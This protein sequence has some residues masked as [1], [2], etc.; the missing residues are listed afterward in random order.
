MMSPSWIV[1]E[2]AMAPRPQVL[3]STERLR[4]L[5]R[6][7]RTARLNDLYYGRQLTIWSRMIGTHDVL[8]AL[9]T[10]ASPIAFWKS[11]SDPRLHGAWVT[12]SVFT[13]ILGALKPMLSM[14]DRLKVLSEL[15]T[16]YCELFFN[17]RDLSNEAA[18]RQ[19]YTDDLDKQ[20]ALLR[21]SFS[22]LAAE[23]RWEP[24]LK[25]VTELQKRVNAEIPPQ[26]LWMPTK[27]EAE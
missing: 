6:D 22:R 19:A 27:G 15:R 17:L 16:Q 11:S 4:Q 21:K 18:A 23:D 13:F 14:Q 5:Y 9:G 2:T 3:D 7:L 1:K 25:V 12:L 24:N 8:L 10:T 26:T 20:Y